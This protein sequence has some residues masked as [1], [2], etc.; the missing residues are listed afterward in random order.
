MKK[1]DADGELPAR[2]PLKFMPLCYKCAHRIFKNMPSHAVMAHG[3]KVV[4]QVMIGCLANFR[5]K[6]YNGAIRFCPLKAEIAKSEK[7]IVY[8]WKELKVGFYKCYPAKGR[9][10]ID[11][12]VLKGQGDFQGELMVRIVKTTPLGLKLIPDKLKNFPES[13]IFEK[14]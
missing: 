8:P 10:P 1:I 3:K 7:Q 6:S 2:E 13:A 4:P 14:A 5:I 9:Q 11:M 12:E